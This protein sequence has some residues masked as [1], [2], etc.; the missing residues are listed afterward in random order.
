V[1]FLIFEEVLVPTLHCIGKFAISE[2]V[3]LKDILFPNGDGRRFRIIGPPK[4]NARCV[5]STNQL[6]FQA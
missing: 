5:F 3:V 4:C 6:G 1:V 2:W